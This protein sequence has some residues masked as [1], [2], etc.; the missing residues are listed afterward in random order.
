M[1]LC[2]TTG[3]ADAPIGGATQAIDYRG[4][5]LFLL[6]T[7]LIT[8]LMD[9]KIVHALGGRN[10]ALAALAFAATLW[11]FLAQEKKFASP[12]IDL[13]LFSKST[14]AYGS[15]GLLLCNI[16]QG[17]VTFVAPF[18]LQDVLKLSPT[19]IGMM[20]LA[21]SILSMVLSPVSGT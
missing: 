13:T 8:L 3:R 15:V 18:Y 12:M 20:F 6:L 19:F 16:A 2:F 4:A 9:Q 21:P 10:Q 7:I 14:F 11:F 1:T 5:A 17:L